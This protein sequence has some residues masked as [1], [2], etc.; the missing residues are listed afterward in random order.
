MTTTIEQFAGLTEE[1]KALLIKAPVL[2]SML[3]AGGDNDLSEHEKAEVIKQAHL[4]TYTGTELLHP[5]YSE[6]DQQFQANFDVA[7]SLYTPF[8][9]HKRARLTQEADHINRIISKLEPGFAN[10]LRKSLGDYGRHVK[11]ADKAFVG[12]YLFPFA[13]S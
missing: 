2:I 10:T 3:A 13:S 5:Y 8:D 9:D 11:Y 1:E 7:L 4:K 12:N 6:V